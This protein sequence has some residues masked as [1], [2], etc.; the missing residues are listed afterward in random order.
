VLNESPLV[1]N[2]VMIPG[3]NSTYIL[4][5][6]RF[7]GNLDEVCHK[8]LS[9]CNALQSGQF[10]DERT[11]IFEIISLEGSCWK[12]RSHLVITTSGGRAQFIISRYFSIRARDL[13]K[14]FLEELISQ[15]TSGKHSCTFS[16]M[17][18]MPFALQV[19]C[20]RERRICFK[21]LPAKVMYGAASVTSNRTSSEKRS[22]L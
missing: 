14:T 16:H 5:K 4:M 13:K 9:L 8:T 17:W 10:I 12:P 21:F 11:K 6:T 15:L 18:W 19:A 1:C 22:P 7:E 2:F 3:K 20:T